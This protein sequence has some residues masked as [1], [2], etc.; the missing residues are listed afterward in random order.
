MRERR[1]GIGVRNKV[2]LP[3]IV[4]IISETKQ[5]NLCSVS[6]QDHKPEIDLFVIL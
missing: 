3:K 4:W 6:L 2:N 5:T 1:V